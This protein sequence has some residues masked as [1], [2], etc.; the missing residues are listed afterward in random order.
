[1]IL[2]N[3]WKIIFTLSIISI[4]LLFFFGISGF[5]KPIYTENL[6]DK[7]LEKLPL[8]NKN[9]IDIIEQNI[10]NINIQING[11]LNKSINYINIPN[12]T[13]SYNKLINISKNLIQITKRII[14]SSISLIF[15]E[16]SLNLNNNTKIIDNS[17]TQI[18][19]YTNENN[20]NKTINDVESIEIID[21]SCDF[22]RNTYNL[23]IKNNGT[24]N[25]ILENVEVKID[26][27]VVKSID[28]DNINILESN[29]TVFVKLNQISEEGK[30]YKLLLDIGENEFKYEITC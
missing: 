5:L 19:N 26:N 20:K 22:V 4:I 16:E 24:K 1:M 8:E 28:W 11:D 9:R 25:I 18:S 13:N 3:L 29:N 14:N 12:S 23:I 15:A 17:S 6:K 30:N 27:K 21:V 7:N 10:D 2:N